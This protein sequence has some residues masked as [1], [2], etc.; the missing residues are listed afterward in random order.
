[1]EILLFLFVV[2]MV[3]A[4]VYFVTGEF[5]FEPLNTDED[6]DQ[7]YPAVNI[8]PC[9]NACQAAVQTSQMIFLSMQAPKLPLNACDRIADCECTF[10]HFAD[11]RQHGDRREVNY[12][13]RDGIQQKDRRAIK[14]VGRRVSDQY[15]VA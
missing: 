6:D 8:Q 10:R 4:L 2:I 13:K 9:N 7:P 12:V 5:E 14:R 11:R 15:S 3:G 1:M